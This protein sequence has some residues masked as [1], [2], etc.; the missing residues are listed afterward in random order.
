M[1]LYILLLPLYFVSIDMNAQDTISLEEKA[2]IYYEKIGKR[3]NEEGR[4]YNLEYLD[5]YGYPPPVPDPIKGYPFS[6]KFFKEIRD[7]LINE[8]YK[9]SECVETSI[10]Y[11]EEKLLI[12]ELKR[13]GA[14]PDS[15]FL[16]LMDA[17]HNIAPKRAVNFCVLRWDFWK[18]HI[19]DIVKYHEIPWIKNYP[20][21][22]FL[23]DNLTMPDILN[24]LLSKN[25]LSEKRN[26]EFINLCIRE[27]KYNLP[28][29][30]FQLY[31]DYINSLRNLINNDDELN[32][33]FL[34]KMSNEK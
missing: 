17:Y 10:D 32:M 15:T 23:F 2:N 12:W 7:S 13:G 28:S 29:N 22:V 4:L 30:E 11:L 31:V 16:V 18:H 27:L 3:Y 1:K 24:L 33:Y 5:K 8:Y 21:V 34:K 20:Y 14:L 6:N 9:K 25:S 19:V 26:E